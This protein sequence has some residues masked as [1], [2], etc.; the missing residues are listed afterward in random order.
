MSLVALTLIRAH[1][2]LPPIAK[3]TMILRFSVNDQFL[4]IIILLLI[5]G[6]SATDL[7]FNVTPPSRWIWI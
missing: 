5:Y 6:E 1:I 4:T 2:I 7:N 3:P